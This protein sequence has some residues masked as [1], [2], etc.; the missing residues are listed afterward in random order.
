MQYYFSLFLFA[1]RF[2]APDAAPVAGREQNDEEVITPLLRKAEANHLILYSDWL[3]DF[4][5]YKLLEL[6][7]IPGSHNSATARQSTNASWI[8]R[9]CFSWARQQSFSVAEQLSMGVRAIDFRLHPITG[10]DEIRISHSLDT[11]YSLERGLQEIKEFLK[12]H[13]TEFVILF[14]RI[15]YK[16]RFLDVDSDETKRVRRR[17]AKFLEDS[18]LFFANVNPTENGLNISEVKVSNLAGKVLL[19]TPI[20]DD[21][22]VSLLETGSFYPPRVDFDSFRVVDIWRN[23]FVNSPYGAKYTLRKHMEE[24]IIPSLPLSHL[25]GISIDITTLLIPAFTSPRLNNWFLNQLESNP[26][27]KNR[28]EASPI[29]VLQVDFVNP[30]LMGRIMQLFQSKSKK[31]A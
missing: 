29:G 4:Q 8:E 3:K 24:S 13:P 28:F 12:A 18:E 11:D 6:P 7:I 22:R 2:H 30:V 5:E 10:F 23:K 9:L 1:S 19:Y 25:R 16:Y 14:L 21:D 26:T 15:D 31:R 27:W 20:G 17:V